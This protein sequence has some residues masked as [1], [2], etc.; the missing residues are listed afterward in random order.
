MDRINF[1][2]L[3]NGR[4]GV[5]TQSDRRTYSPGDMVDIKKRDGSWSRG[6]RLGSVVQRWSYANTQVRVF[7]IQR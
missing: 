7:T 2:R 4:W 3:D 5:K 1:Q 6:I